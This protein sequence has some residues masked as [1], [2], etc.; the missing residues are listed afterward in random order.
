MTR[1]LLPTLVLFFATLACGDSPKVELHK[2]KTTI[3][4]LASFQ[5]SASS[6]TLFSDGRIQHVNHP[7][8]GEPRLRTG[9]LPEKVRVALIARAKEQGLDTLQFTQK[10][11][12]HLLT[13]GVTRLRVLENLL[14]PPG[15]GEFNAESKAILA[16]MDAFAKDLAKTFA[17]HLDTAHP[18]GTYVYVHVFSEE[19]QK[20]LQAMPRYKDKLSKLEEVSSPRLRAA[21]ETP[22]L[23]VRLEEGEEVTRGKMQL[24]RGRA[25]MWNTRRFVGPKPEG[26]R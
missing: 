12:P 26:D 5:G 23:L 9:K 16:K 17:P 3:E 6:W 25:L 22:G 21:L 11:D 2:T 10:D 20:K 15:V 13:E 4:Y 18:A 14:D 8:T 7:L 24:F 1:A 19:D